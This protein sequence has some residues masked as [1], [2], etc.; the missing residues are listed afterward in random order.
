M[1]HGKKIVDSLMFEPPEPQQAVSIDEMG[2]IAM[3]GDGLGIWVSPDG[4]RGEFAG[5]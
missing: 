5:V 3:S 4:C 2:G 1:G